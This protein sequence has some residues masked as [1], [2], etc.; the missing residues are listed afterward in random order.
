[1]I[2]NAT[3]TSTN[4]CEQK[5][6]DVDVV[7]SENDVATSAVMISIDFSSVDAETTAT[8][9]VVNGKHLNETQN[10]EQIDRKNDR[11]GLNIATTPP[12]MAEELASLSPSQSPMHHHAINETDILKEAVAKANM[13]LMQMETVLTQRESMIELQQKELSLLEN[14]KVSI[15]RDFDMA[16]KEKEAAVVRYAMIEKTIMDL[17]SSKDLANKKLKEATKDI[18][19][20]NNRL[21]AVNRER[22]KAQKEHR[23]SIREC[24]ALKCEL[25]MYESKN[26]YNQVKIKQEISAKN[27]IELKLME[28]TSQLS[29]LSEERQQRI[30]SEK[31]S[32]QE[33]GAQ[34]ILLKHLTDEK[35]K[36]INAVQRK[37]AQ[38]TT[39]FNDVSDKYNLLV[40][41][42]EYEKIEKSRYQE[43]AIEF[44]Q[45]LQLK[46]DQFDELE[47][48]LIKCN[49][50]CETLTSTNVD[51]NGLL[52][53]L[54]E[55]EEDYHDQ[56]EEMAQIRA[57][58]D[59]QLAYMKDLT[60]KC[61][62]VENQLILTTS[63]ASALQLENDKIKREYDVQQDTIKDLNEQLTGVK[64]K[65]SDEA[66]VFGR[67]LTEQKFN[68]DQIRK[69]LEN[70][71]GELITQ[72]RKHTQNVKDLNRQI[73]ELKSLRESSHCSVQSLNGTRC[74]TNPNSTDHSP[75]NSS[76]DG[77]CKSST[78]KEPTTKALIGRIARLQAVL[79]KQT[80]KI[81]FLENHCIA[82]TNELRG[83]TT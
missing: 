83:K 26:K 68:C 75:C 9:H 58:E 39:E 1:M 53:Q 38:L 17:N 21:K 79:A 61:V 15:K 32:E 37:L 60:E 8:A 14:E 11:N 54:K 80:E 41:D 82:L 62:S 5:I 46:N 43:K 63:K 56:I 64:Q 51:L 44:E 48:Q 30:D 66:T 13:Q 2:E 33:Q 4:G 49:A 81:E 77:D 27:A 12:V 16:K 40:V 10:R 22:D 59:E 47:K 34:V 52:R 45:S 23:D 36:E 74:E 18:E 78:P 50:Q 19:Q 76:T 20:L 35:D 55:T 70:A 72:N 42:H 7:D 71:Q 73:L 57:N 29:Q 31:R 28:V 25:Q 67:L 6:D 69:E 65:R 3:H 24:E